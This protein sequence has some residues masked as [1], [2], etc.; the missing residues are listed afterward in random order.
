MPNEFI[1]MISIRQ[2]GILP[3]AKK[4]FV[5]LFQAQMIGLIW[6][7]YWCSTVHGNN[8]LLMLNS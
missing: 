1:M 6:L 5:Y 7:I 8:I 2:E 3:L 4:K